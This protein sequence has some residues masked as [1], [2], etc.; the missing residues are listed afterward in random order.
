VIGG[1]IPNW[2]H[3][4]VGGTLLEHPETLAFNW[5]PLLTSLVVS[6]GGLGLGYYAYR[7]IRA[8]A[9]DPLKKPLGKIYTTLQNA[10]YFDAFYHKVF[11]RPSFWI[12]EKFTYAFMD[13]KVI[14]GFLHWI[15]HV[16]SVIG[17]FLRNAID[18]PIVNGFGDLVGEV[19][20]KIGFL[21]RPIQTG[22]IQ[23][24]MIMALVTLATFTILFYYLFMNAR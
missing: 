9:P 14:D 5:I 1:I 3:E 15:A 6:L 19:T 11:V 21:F 17:N 12:A 24:Y 10:Y 18:K 4:F 16:T 23:Q 2:F 8:G 7:S 20:K 22:K 13:R